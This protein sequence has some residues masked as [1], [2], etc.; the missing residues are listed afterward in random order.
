MYHQIQQVQAVIPLL[1]VVFP[2]VWRFLDAYG[3]AKVEL[4]FEDSVHSSIAEVKQ[5]NSDSIAEFIEIVLW[6]T[7]VSLVVFWLKCYG[8]GCQNSVWLCHC[9]F[10]D[11][12]TLNPFHSCSFI[13][14]P[15][16]MLL[17]MKFSSKVTYP[18]KEA[19]LQDI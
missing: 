14:V 13:L 16:I 11:A 18:F 1:A 7:N 15:C 6:F 9:F 5:W 17:S 12:E 3:N 2:T 8:K 19:V 10:I 4:S